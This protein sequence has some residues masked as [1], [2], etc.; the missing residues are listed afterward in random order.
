MKKKIL[1]SVGIIA[2]SMFFILPLLAQ[3]ESKVA[4]LTVSGSGKTQE[5]AKQNALRN[6]IEQAFGTFISSNTQILNDNLVK[7]EIVSVSNG[8]IQEYAVISEVQ[9]QDG[10]WSSTLRAKVAID[11]LTSFC[12]SK[13]VKVE[14][15][16][17]LFALNVK[18][19][20]LNKKNEEQAI[21]NMCGVLKEM[22]EKC[23]DYEIKPGEPKASLGGRTKTYDIPISIFVTPNSNMKPISDYFISTL[24]G[25][26]VSESEID[27]YKKNG[28]EIYSF[29][30]QQPDIQDAISAKLNGDKKDKKN[31]KQA[32]P[33]PAPNALLTIFLRSDKSINDIE[34][35]LKYFRKTL[36]NFE[37][38]NNLDSL[39]GNDFL[40]EGRGNPNINRILYPQRL[41]GVQDIGFKPS[42][43]NA[44]ADVEK[45]FISGDIYHS[46][47]EF[48]Y[49]RSR[50]G[51][52]AAFF[53]RLEDPYLDFSEYKFLETRYPHD[54][55]SQVMDIKGNGISFKGIL[56][57][58][59]V[60]EIGY[61]DKRTTD[62][63][64]RISGYKIMFC[65]NKFQRQIDPNNQSYYIYK[66]VK[67]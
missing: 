1:T 33:I 61:I 16:G 15:K 66:A 57:G 39:L 44:A 35:F 52:N 24:K 30:L 12:E 64:S 11:K 6:A 25:L 67:Q 14:F 20:E 62:E 9:T 56:Y 59:R 54:I 27:N 17:A 41:L 48:E 42:F 58:I 55:T 3:T 31:K 34:D 2:I 13:G 45:S 23:F 32:E 21:K 4:I 63:I 40:R 36:L 60:I 50:D 37:I 28:N 49:L 47:E 7:D 38:I 53:S 19:Q 29:K 22:S 26:S 8:N 65:K 43:I 10:N 5:E 18:Q 51:P 46:K